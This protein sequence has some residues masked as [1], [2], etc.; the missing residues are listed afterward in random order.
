MSV[1]PKTRQRKLEQRAA[2]RKA[3]QHQLVQKKSAGI[4]ERLTSAARFPV[5][6]SWVTNNLWTHG[7]GWIGMSRELPDGSIAVAI[8]LV[9]R[10]CLGVKDALAKILPP[11][12]YENQIRQRQRQMSSR[13]VPPATVRKFV[14]GA[15]AYAQ[16][17]GL[18]PH[19]DYHKAKL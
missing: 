7:M 3:K 11:S 9:D 18:P 12:T 15:V 6:D 2:K 19:P 4:A 13:E 1:N 14:E 10:Y 5:L 17:L 8:F 16:T